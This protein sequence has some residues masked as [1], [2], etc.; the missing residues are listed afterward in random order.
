MK[1]FLLAFALLTATFSFSQQ[2]PTAAIP[3]TP[4]SFAKQNFYPAVYTLFTEKDDG[5]MDMHCTATAF[6]V[7]PSDHGYHLVRF[8]SAGHCVQKGGGEAVLFP[9]LAPT[10]SSKITPL[11]YY[12]SLDDG[13]DKVF[14]RAKFIASG[15]GGRGEDFSVWEL[16]TKEDIPTM[17]LGVDPLDA[18]DEPIINISNPMGLGKQVFRGG[19]SRLNLDRHGGPEDQDWH[20]DMLVQLFGVDGGSSGS[21]LMCSNQRAICGFIIGYFGEAHST[22]VATKVSNFKAWYTKSQ[23]PQSPIDE[24]FKM[25][26]GKLGVVPAPPPKDKKHPTPPTQKH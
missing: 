11:T 25:L 5:G 14:L 4:E 13:D 2:K 12:L 8:A 22:M 10:S 23:S 24:V 7:K 6:E 1:I 9:F 26:Q 19:V 18:F 20:G 17:P 15:D 16:R 21:A 3:L